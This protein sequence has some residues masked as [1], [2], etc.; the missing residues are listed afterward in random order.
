MAYNGYLLKIGD[1]EFPKEWIQYETF[2]VVKGIQDLDSYRDANGVLHRNVLSHQ[3]V[4]VEFQV[5][6][7]MNSTTY[8]SIMT[9]IQSR[10]II[11]AERKCQMDCYIPETASYSGLTNVYM[12]DPEVV[13]KKIEG[14]ELIYK[15]IRFAF[16][17]Y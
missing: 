4:K 16:I 8:D 17:G 2:K 6:E 12:P 5:R 14:N 11:A 15:S 1:Y 13:I 3:I 10:Y 7:N 9:N